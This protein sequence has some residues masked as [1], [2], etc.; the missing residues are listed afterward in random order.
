MLGITCWV[1]WGDA[2]IIAEVTGYSAIIVPVLCSSD[3]TLLVA[4][5]MIIKHVS[6]DY[7]Y[8]S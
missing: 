2:E 6:A 4:R 7:S 5:H 1:E 8:P 3:I